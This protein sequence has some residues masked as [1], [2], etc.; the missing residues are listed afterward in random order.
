MKIYMVEFLDFEVRM[1]LYYNMNVVE[2][3]DKKSY[4]KEMENLIKKGYIDIN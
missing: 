3:Y 2:K 4:R 1:S